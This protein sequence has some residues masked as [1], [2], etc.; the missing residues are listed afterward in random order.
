VPRDLESLIRT[1]ETWQFQREAIFKRSPFN[2]GANASSL[3]E[4]TEVMNR[5]SREMIRTFEKEDGGFFTALNELAMNSN[6]LTDGG[7]IFVDGKDRTS[8]GM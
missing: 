5:L 8:E 6:R 7:K 2:E 3:R 1:V 4:F